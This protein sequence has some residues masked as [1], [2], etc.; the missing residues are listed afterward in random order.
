MSAELEIAIHLHRV[1]VENTPRV[2]HGG[3]FMRGR[4]A[5]F[6]LEGA[7]VRMIGVVR[8]RDAGRLAHHV[9]IMLTQQH[10]AGTH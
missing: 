7:A 8:H 9:R 1:S 2:S 10:M 5:S 3:C 4:V 6:R